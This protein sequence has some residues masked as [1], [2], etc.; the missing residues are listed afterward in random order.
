MDKLNKVIKIVEGLYAKKNPVIDWNSWILEG[1]LKVVAAWVEDISKKSK[2]D[3]ESTIAAAYLHDL[4]Y[5]WTDKFDPD[6]DEKSESEARKV[7]KEAGYSEDKIIF[8]VDK[9]IHGHGM[10]DGKEP[11]HIEAKVL[12]TADAFAHFSTDFY[13]V[14]CWNHYLFENK[15]L[16]TYKAWVLKKIERDINNKIFFK[17]Y[18][19]LAEPYYKS[20]KTLFSLYPSKIS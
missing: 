10:Y 18:K 16:N 1:H 9:I 6:L 7:L 8:I 14:V 19:K 3:K 4:A 12:A 20:L 13:L 2:F 15:D 11:E 5:A 17:E